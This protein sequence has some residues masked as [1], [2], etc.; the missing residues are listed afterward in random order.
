MG[1][2]AKTGLC[3]PFLG[4]TL[5]AGVPHSTFEILRRAEQVELRSAAIYG[6][7]AERFAWHGEAGRLFATLHEEELQHAN[8]IRLL[9]ARY[10]HDKSLFD[11]L[12]VDMSEV[13]RLEAES[14]RVL[15]AV[16]GGA[17]DD[18]FDVLRERLAVMEDAYVRLHAQFIAPGAHPALRTFFEVLAMQDAAHA[19]LLSDLPSLA[20]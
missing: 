11:G 2:T 13:E 17:F 19:R 16:Q 6:A 12:A 4:R 10:A 3:G 9:A 20:P 14:E 1:R 7:L 8:R 15:E 18:Q 5:R